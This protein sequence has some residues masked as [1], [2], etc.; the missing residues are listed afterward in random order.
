MKTKLSKLT[1]VRKI[2]IIIGLI[3]LI[4]THTIVNLQAA[5]ITKDQVPE[6]LQ[7]WVDWV[8]YQQDEQTCP[9]AYNSD[10]RFCA[11]PS[12]LK[13]ELD[14]DQGHFSQ[15]WQTQT[16]SWVRLPG[17]ALQ[18][19]HDVE[20]NSIAAVVVNRQ[21]FPAV[22]LPKGEHQISGGFQWDTLPESLTI[23]PTTGLVEISRK[24]VVMDFPR[25]NQQGQLWLDKSIQQ[26]NV[27]DALDVQVYRKIND[28]HPMQV[29]TRF[30]LNVSGRSRDVIF[31]HVQLN[32]FIAL[33][34]TSPL[35]ARIN[36]QGDL[37]V[38]V[39]PGNWV[40]SLVSYSTAMVSELTAPEL[41]ANMPTQEVWVFQA[42]P[43]L[44]LTEISG[45][46]SIDS[47]QTRLPREWKPFPAYLIEPKKVL[48]LT[49]LQRGS[50]S[51]EPNRLTLNRTM[52][53]DFDGKGFTID[54]R[55]KG[56]MTR[57]WRLVAG[58]ELNLGSV[59]MDNEPQFITTLEGNADKG[60]EV[61]RGK[62]DLQAASRLTQSVSVLPVTGWNHD[63][64]QVSTR[65]FLAPGWKLFSAHGADNLPNTWLQHWTLLDLFMV[66]II[67]VAVGR[68][69]DWKWGVFAL[70]TMT[71]IWHEVGAPKYIW[72]NLVAAIALLR[73]LP[74]GWAK[75][76]VWWYRNVL[77]LS[78]L[79]IVLPFV[80]SEVRSGLYPQLGK[81]SDYDSPVYSSSSGYGMGANK[82]SYSTSVLQDDMKESDVAFE[83]ESHRYNIKK[84]R[85]SK[86]SSSLKPAP[87][88]VRVNQMIDPNA[89][90]QTGPGLPT[91]NWQEVNFRWDSPV[92]ENQTLRLNLMSPRMNL[93]L[94]FLRVVLLLLLMGRLILV[95]TGDSGDSESKRNKP[96]K[97]SKKKPLH[98]FSKLASILLLAILLLP[99]PDVSAESMAGMAKI[100]KKI[101]VESA[102]L[103]SKPVQTRN[104]LL[105]HANHS[106]IGF[107]NN[108]MLQTLRNRLL[109][110]EDC[111]SECGQ[112][113]AMRLEISEQ[114]LKVFLKIHSAAT[115]AIPLPGHSEQW[116]PDRVLLENQPAKSITRDSK[117]QL[118]IG[119]SKGVHN[120]LMQGRL[121]KQPQ[122]QLSLPLQPK[123][124]EWQG[125]GWTVEGIRENHRP[126]QQLQL[127]RQR[128]GEAQSLED[129]LATENNI[130]PP[131]LR[132]SRT[133][134]LGLDWRVE[135]RVSRLSPSG[136]PVSMKI[137]LLKNES[138]LSNVYPVKK[139]HVLINLSSTENEVSWESKLSVANELLLEATSQ[140][141]LV[142]SWKL[143]ISPIWHVEIIG[144]PEIHHEN[145]TDAWLPEWQPWPGEKVSLR[146]SRPKG[147][148][149]RT[150][151]IDRSILTT[152][153]GKRLRES[154]LILNLRSSRGGQHLITIPESAELMS[155][156]INNKLQPVRQKLNHVSLPIVPGQQRII[157]KWRVATPISTQLTSLP[158][159]IGVDSVNNSIH[160]KMGQDR[161][162]LFTN[163]P[164]MGPAV[165]FWGMLLVI[166]I[167]SII[168]GRINNSPLRTWQWFLLGM[169]LS[170]A[171]PVML[172]IV[173]GWL[174]ALNYRPQLQQVANRLVFN[175]VQV[176]LVLLTLI[177]LGAL[178]LALQQGLLGWPDM[179]IS[180]NGSSAW[181]LSWYQD[182]VTAQLPQPWVISVP[183]LAYRILM[184]LWAL[185]LAFSLIS[186]LRQGWHNFTVGG[187]W[188]AKEKKVAKVIE[189]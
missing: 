99:I 95:F 52:W 181:D 140:Q 65:L 133:L 40:I 6:P 71:L 186:W 38:Q 61:R 19:P 63:F 111:L 188:K 58:S 161:W 131:L 27:Q 45:V 3:L 130:L 24:G 70:L 29:E 152:Q 164:V 81:Y 79:L 147:I 77:F 114:Q 101:N 180:G 83:Q 18:W 137:P 84:K 21:G 59:R 92:N 156:S 157:V 49:T 9:H 51:P 119:L 34:L 15:Y 107:P 11:W 169:G 126:S 124:I 57:G 28:G 94:N 139:G 153:I 100:E 36:Q 116:R 129:E 20:V 134:H 146:V 170:L 189:G 109:E 69:W 87:K 159:D 171:T 23:P 54:D 106:Y 141:G 39:R 179:Q 30:I 143:D 7:P 1:I 172:L 80:V 104:N 44:R 118:W 160:L 17:N 103:V 64:Q 66:L 166:L 75:K 43:S 121:P 78:L 42:N 86:M 122:L 37:Q 90:I 142:E 182:R 145:Q 98:R 149:G 108:K 174:L 68:L 158:V 72:L 115:V 97:R 178:M 56:T 144:I 96:K 31:P 173:V 2:T 148:V 177:A 138:V 12:T 187:L 112:I 50:A 93:I 5:P 8:M 150:L 82:M 127:I 120:V 183:L 154:E 176:L 162:I 48:T 14:D 125:E 89:N 55:L 10:R 110:K 67:A 60:V 32:Q 73:V 47:R 53:M 62:I 175:L 135:T 102:P 26:K 136:T 91:W 123:Y 105:S 22:K 117:G 46:A 185:W 155:V 168:M 132:V 151:T 35:P 4:L 76:M 113:E 41:S 33:N 128:T 88:K 85:V 167:G 13:L 163:G 25:I 16:E 165:L 184:L 74:E